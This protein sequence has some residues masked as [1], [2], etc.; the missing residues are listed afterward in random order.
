MSIADRLAQERRARLGAERLLEL[1][2]AELF[3]ANKKLNTH[4]K[5]LNAEIDETRA[6][7]AEVNNENQQVRSENQQVRQ[8]NRVVRTKLG[9]ANEKIELVEGQLWKALKSVRDGFAMFSADGQLELAN[10]AFMTIFDGLDSVGIG[11]S[12]GHI[13]EMMVEEGIID[14]QGEDGRSF[15]MRAKERIQKNPIPVAT[16]R[17]WNGRFIKIRDRRTPDGGIVSLCVD[18][19]D[20]MR[21]WSAVEEMPEGFVLYDSDE[22]LITCNDPYRQI[23]D[24]STDLVK[25]GV[26]YEALLR[27][28]YERGQFSDTG[29]EV[30]DWVTSRLTAF[31]AATGETDQKL[32]NGRWIRNFDRPLRDGGRLGLRIDITD[33]KHQEQELHQAMINAEAASRAKSSF[34]ANM[35][36]EIRTPMNGVVSMAELM[37]ETALSEEQRLFAETIRSSGDALLV[38]INDV[39][40]YSKIEA[41]R[42]SL[43]SENFDLEQCVHEVVMLLQPAA[44]QKG[45]LILVDYDMFLP[46]RFIGDPG[47]IRQILT[48]LIG[49][50]VKFTLEGHILVHVSGFVEG[51]KASIHMAVEDTG[52]GIP[53]EKKDCVFSEFSQVDNENNRKFE[54]TGLGLAITKRLVEL[55]NGEIWVESE[56][57]KGSYFGLRIEIPLE[58]DQTVSHPVV[59]IGLRHVAVVASPGMYRNILSKQLKFLEFDVDFFVSGDAFL[60]V[61]PMKHDLILVEENLPDMRAVDLVQALRQNGHTGPVLLLSDQKSKVKQEEIDVFA[62]VLLKP[63]ARK[64]LF[65]VV[66]RLSALFDTDWVDAEVDAYQ[67]IENSAEITPLEEDRQSEAAPPDT[68]D[69]LNNRSIELAQVF[70]LGQILADNKPSS[71]IFDKQAAD[72]P[73]EIMSLGTIFGSNR[74]LEITPD[75]NEP[76]V[77]EP[78]VGKSEEKPILACCENEGIQEHHDLPAEAIAPQS[79]QL[80]LEGSEG[81]GEMKLCAPNLSD[82]T[83]QIDEK[84]GACPMEEDFASLDT[85]QKPSTQDTI[86]EWDAALSV[87]DDPHTGLEGY[88]PEPKAEVLASDGRDIEELSEKVIPPDNR[89]NVLVAEDNKTNQLVF[90]K[91]VAGYDLNLRFANNGQEALDCYQAERPDIIFM[92]I[93]MPIM[94]GKEATAHIRALESAGCRT[95]II[96]VTAHAVEGDKETILEAGLDDYLTK[97]VRKAEIS[98]KLTQYAEQIASCLAS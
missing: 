87:P 10:P 56:L 34:L 51:E 40:D 33:N 7:V 82:E 89:L 88:G 91:M 94:D 86:A 63:V 43:T 77:G 20:L 66:E 41:D 55:M 80:V 45:I 24:V 61:N 47:R 44:S 57:G 21:M 83:L 9:E 84:E 8:E 58:L 50:A 11:S 48:N 97:P 15:L 75:D 13:A 29:S 92:D 78:Q 60:Q 30:E 79:S 37:L 38:I 26:P 70:S 46:A 3:A 19:T 53:A 25:P 54:G 5:R 69:V 95:P 71:R 39:L 42:L 73:D 76:P 72:I 18:T 62:A 81:A 22:R 96:A 64:T 32:S 4:A 98:A 31:R 27:S 1:K 14:L 93:S 12:Y 16:I 67:E 49:N 23:F 28:G 2:Q 6:R 36:H 59:P 74:P 68:S 85:Q 52:I 90:R 65:T 17:L 35:S